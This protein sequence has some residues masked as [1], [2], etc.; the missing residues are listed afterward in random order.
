MK[1]QVDQV[2][3]VKQMSWKLNTIAVVAT[4]VALGCSSE[5]TVLE[6]G[7]FNF[8]GTCVNCHV[9][10]SAGQVHPTFKLRCV[11]CHGGN[12]DV[13][14][15][16]DAFENEAVYR[17]PD[18][19]AQA[20]VLPKAGLA[21]HFWANGADDD[22]DGV[23]DEPI[24]LNAAGDQVLD[25]GEIAELGLQG[26]GV[27]DFIDSEINRDLNYLRWTNPGDLRVA[28]IGCGSGNSQALAGEAGGACHQSIVETNRRSIMVNNAAVI[29]GA[30]YGNTSWNP[31]FQNARDDNN[32]G[33][34]EI[35]PREGAFGY[36]LNYAG[37]DTCIDT[38]DFDADPDNGQPVFDSDCLEGLAAGEDPNAVANGPGNSGLPAF[39]ITQGSIVGSAPGTEPGSTIEHV[40]ASKNNR[41]FWGGKE[42]AIPDAPIQ[43]MDPVPD[44]DLA[45]VG[46]AGVPNPV[47]NILR[48]FR[49]YYPAGY[50]GSNNNFFF[51][52]GQSIRPDFDRHRTNNPFG[53][54]HS[55]GCTG[56]HMTYNET[57]SREPQVVRS[58]DDTGNLVE[59][60]ITDPTTKHRE[61]TED[62]DTAM[63]D[64]ELR[65]IGRTVNVAERDIDGDGT[66]DREQQRTYSKDHKLTTQI[67][68]D[69]CGLC[70][71]FV[72][73]IDY[74]Y[75]GT[76][77]DEQRDVL[78]RFAPISFTTPTGTQV[79]IHDSWVREDFDNTNGQF[80]RTVIPEGE[81]IAQL[82]R[83]RNAELE[84][85]GLL[86]G[87]G[88]CGQNVFSEDCNNNGELDTS[89]L[90]QRFDENGNLVASET[91]NEDLNGNGRLDLLSHVPRF[92]SVDGRQ[93]RYV[94]GGANG[95]TRLMD[96]HFE[97]GMHCIDCHMIQDTH[98]DGNIYTTNWEQIEIECED[99]HGSTERATLFTSGP[100]GGNDLTRAFDLDRRPFFERKGNAIIQRSRVTPGVFWEVPQVPDTVDP[101]HP[102]FEQR[103]V[104]AH[105]PVHLPPTVG[106][107]EFNAGSQ[108]A[109]EPGKS[110]VQSVVLECYTCH[111]SWTH[112]CM[113]CHFNTNLG[114]N[115]KQFV[116]A[117]GTII[118]VPGE[119]ETWFNNKNQA[120]R[121]NFQLLSLMRSPFVLGINS[122]ADAQRLS[123][124]RSNMEVLVS[125]IGPTG[126]LLK[127][128]MTFTTFQDVDANSGRTEVATSGSAMNQHMPHTVRPFETQG[129]ESCHG[130]VDQDQN[131]LNDHILGQTY[132]IG[133][134]RYPYTGN[135]A[136]I[137]GVGGLELIEHKADAELPGNN[138]SVFPGLIMSPNDPRTAGVE[139]NFV[140]NLAGFGAT[141]V[142]LIRNFIRSP[143]SVE[144]LQLPSLLD[145]AVVT[146]SNGATGAVL[147]ND[148]TNRNVAGNVNPNAGVAG[149]FVL[150]LAQPALGLDHISPEVSDPFVY[151]ANATAGLTTIEITGDPD[152]LNNASVVSSVAIGGR[153]AT[154][155]RVRGDIAYVGTADGFIEIFDLSDP[156]NP[157]RVGN[158]IDLV[159]EGARVNEIDFG[160]LH[161]YIATDDGVVIANAV[162]IDD[163]FIVGDALLTN[164]PT[165]VTGIFQ[166]NGRL[167]AAAGDQGVLEVDVTNPGNPVDIGELAGPRGETLTN[168]VDVNVSVLP[169]QTWVLVTDDVGGQTDLVGLKLDRRQSTRERCLPDPT[170][171]KQDMDWRDPTIMG[172][173]PTFINGQF[174]VTEPDG[175]PAFRMAGVRVTGGGRL[176]RPAIWEQIGSPTG[177]RV[178]DSFM[179]GSGVLSQQVIQ[180]MYL[181]QVCEVPGTVDVNGSGWGEF[182]FAD[183]DFLATGECVPI[184]EGF[185][186]GGGGEMERVSLVCDSKSE[187]C[188]G[189]DEVRPVRER[190]TQPRPQRRPSRRDRDVSSAGDDKALP[191]LSRR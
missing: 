61:F 32:A 167:Y 79:T 39:E 33:E 99:C 185:S 146:A 70:H 63:V 10:L 82:A 26:E 75:Q 163:L 12:D 154:C 174:D 95:S 4:L 156:R 54:G 142:A 179:P 183:S 90:L 152:E 175:P 147:F 57:G 97:R 73:R 58:F 64:G 44:T 21:R 84:E 83:A 162:G 123:T 124:F 71:A 176:A 48:G 65:L 143:N 112:N 7:D 151:V 158:G 141:D 122:E 190:S 68:T 30:Y 89:L 109:G 53:R 40:G 149:A 115:V 20:H 113:G 107:G 74:A 168:A 119:N 14:V 128:N 31:I 91:I 1:S 41:F 101:N 11:D 133:S 166:H 81:Q 72:T 121:T 77:E 49:A 120:A 6:D 170:Q 180:R 28:T 173:D 126:E 165:A 43:Q 87:A 2:G 134:N 178:R 137:A 51:T 3:Q 136:M 76:A 15:P 78:A 159:I 132:G 46:L 150:Q 38:S 125:V 37:A 5:E 186:G 34:D 148:I 24:E 116:E 139:A 100:N 160:G 184:T 19:I 13:E 131:V 96:I 47:D 144:N 42:L 67:S 16:E 103:A 191:E 189:T 171:C 161:M 140:G 157:Q 187:F 104:A 66:L 106:P 50:P 111:T 118:Q 45:A 117:D 110:E 94:Y 130:V 56:C 155:V 17:D 55:S 9:G 145:L 102:D 60:D 164:P 88:G 86:A 114:D 135:W 29:N 127:D 108:F 35:D 181:M 172:R 23:V 62:Q 22:G 36:S 169:T 59:E 85:L 177:R 52:F 92:K 138:A 129:C 69:Q 80:I 182:G 188:L 98:G 153:E 105:D 93:L 18:L 27:G 25:F 8:D